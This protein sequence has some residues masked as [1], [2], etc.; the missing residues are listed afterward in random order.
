MPGPLGP[1]F[2]RRL[3]VIFMREYRL[4]FCAH[5][6]AEPPGDDTDPCDHKLT[7]LT[8]ELHNAAAGYQQRIRGVENGQGPF[9]ARADDQGAV[10]DVP[11]SWLEYTARDRD[12]GHRYLRCQENPPGDGPGRTDQ[13]GALELS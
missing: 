7:W 10:A 3:A 1:E 8:V 2:R 13:P 4:D 5:D 9:A 6:P 11:F 12:A